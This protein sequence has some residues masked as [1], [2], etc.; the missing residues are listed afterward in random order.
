VRKRVRAA[1]GYCEP[2]E[3]VLTAAFAEA[4]RGPG[5]RRREIESRECDN[6]YHADYTRVHSYSWSGGPYSYSTAVIIA[7]CI[8]PITGRKGGGGEMKITC[9]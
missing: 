8:R 7:A 6:I 2:R 9:A 5:T 3:W 1:R 4:A